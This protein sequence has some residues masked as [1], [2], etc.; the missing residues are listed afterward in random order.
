MTSLMLDENPV[1]TD[2][3]QPP[4]TR[5]V[6]KIDIANVSINLTQLIAIISAVVAGT[7]AYDAT[8]NRID[9]AE[10]RAI[11]VQS[12]LGELNGRLNAMDHR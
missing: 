9:Q 6:R 7:M 3:E 4:R 1:E 2:T 8:M 12:Q 10:A 11:Q 5:Q